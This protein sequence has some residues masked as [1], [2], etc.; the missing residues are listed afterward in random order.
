M[1]SDTAHQA[2]V[3]AVAVLAV[4]GALGLPFWTD[5]YG[6]EGTA[7][8]VEM[9]G[10]PSE[11]NFNFVTL[12]DVNEDSLPDVI[13]CGAGEDGWRGSAPGGLHILLN[14]GDGSFVDGSEGL[15]RPGDED[16]GET[17]GS[18]AVVDVDGDGHLDLVA[19]EFLT[20]L[21]LP[22][23]VWLG[24]GG[25]GG[26]MSWSK[27]AAPEALS[28][29]RAVACG[30]IDGD[31]HIDLVATGEEGLFVWRGDHS[32]G[33]LSW[34]WA[35]D[36]LP[37]R[38]D[39]LSGVALADLDGDGRLDIVAGSE[40]GSGITVVTCSPSGEVSWTEASSGTD[41]PV[42]GVFWDLRLVDLDGDGDHDLVASGDEG[43]R[44]Y[45]GN[46]N[47]GE[48]ASSWWVDSS[49][50]LPASGTFYQI[51]VG[52]V[53]GDGRPDIAS[54]LRVWSR[55]VPDGA[56]ELWEELDI[57]LPRHFAVGTCLGDVTGDGRQDL[58]G[59]GWEGNLPGIHAYPLTDAGNAGS[60]GP[61][62]DDQGSA[63]VFTT[64]G[65]RSLIIILA[66]VAAAAILVLAMV[67]K[68]R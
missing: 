10:L 61:T 21:D 34:T 46:G 22:I 53:D 18:L 24:N 52:D 62:G 28:S 16:F 6:G 63:S 65:D 49:D 39:Y 29:W 4:A 59:C 12:A 64:I 11:G 47:R 45:I 30:D 68:Q 40:R 26:S 55:T 58:V 14:R 38:L 23:T 66:L 41:L 8:D 31:G 2:I 37:D 3:A 60:E 9:K 17:H 50:G 48:D 54:S 43:L 13:A 25:E 19:C 20:R 36:G 27:A 51:D 42:S 56:G 1:S 67:L 7:E 33:S 35:G 32:P 15:P 44:V 57:G 5:V